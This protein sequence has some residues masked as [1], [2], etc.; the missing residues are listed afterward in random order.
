MSLL[1]VAA[2]PKYRSQVASSPSLRPVSQLHEQVDTIHAKEP[3]TV[4]SGKRD[5]LQAVV[6]RYK[7][8]L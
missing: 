1:C 5:T 7:M 8:E 2:R 6:V 4:P 3:L